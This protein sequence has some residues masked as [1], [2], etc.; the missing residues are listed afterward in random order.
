MVGSLK[1]LPI[2]KRDLGIRC[3]LDT[4]VDTLEEEV[5]WL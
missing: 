5:N 3:V 4:I 2:G 1:N